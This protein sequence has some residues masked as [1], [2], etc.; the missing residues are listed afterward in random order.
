MTA[1]IDDR[2]RAIAGTLDR[3][4]ARDRN[5][6]VFASRTHGYRL[7]PPADEALIAA[8]EQRRGVT[9]PEEY[10]AFITRLGSAGAGPCYGIEARGERED[11]EVDVAGLPFPVLREEA[12]ALTGQLEDDDEERR[13]NAIRA[14]LDELEEVPGT[15]RIVH[16]GCG[17]YYR[18]II[19]GELRG[20]IWFDEP[21][22]PMRRDGRLLSFLDWYEGWLDGILS[23][24][25]LV[26]GDD[27]LDTD[28]S[29]EA[30]NF[31]GRKLEALPPRLFARRELRRLDLRGNQLAALPEE[32]GR[33]TG[34]RWLNISK[35]AL[36][37]LPESLGELTELEEIS[38]WDNPLASLPDGIGRL[39]RL[40]RLSISTKTLARL[41]DSFGGLAELRDL[42]L[43]FNALESLPDSFGRLA[44]L[45]EL[46][47]V[48]NKLE[49]LPDTLD[50]LIELR[51]L[52]LS[53]NRL[54]DLPESLVRLP[55]L[56]RLDL[57]RN[58]FRRLPRWTPWLP[59]VAR[60]G[61]GQN[62][63][64]DVA[65]TCALLA[66]APRLRDLA[67]YGCKLTTLPDEIGALTRLEILSLAHNDLGGLPPA[68]A[69]LTSLRTLY[70]SNNPNAKELAARARELLP[71]A[72][73]R[74]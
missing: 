70:L 66:G 63:E 55:K 45:R 3:V 71:N 15:L 52:D 12:L 65:D 51:E 10:R 46:K 30:I 43:G 23:P 56:A 49:A 74:L 41:P 25:Y 4:R 21:W 48:E 62:P 14:R 13:R 31:A 69:K 47:L 72:E 32:I 67:L 24:G 58:R 26:D 42:Y 53:C 59:R 39:R 57:G 38:C 8:W 64:L 1:S 5:Y 20:T 40:R 34:L 33:L 18:L 17:G 29:V 27:V 28:G 11:E 37:T 2:L 7:A 19:T 6:E 73:I 61:L 35:N 44:A 22:Q 9:L 60:L 50:G 68:L 54:T 36:A 16:A